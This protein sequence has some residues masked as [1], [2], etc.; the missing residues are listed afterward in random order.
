MKRNNRYKSTYN[1]ALKLIADLPLASGLPTETVLSKQLLASRT[2]I[3]A[4]LSQLASER[5]IEWRGRTKLV[6]RRPI[7]D[8]YYVFAETQS[9][10]QLIET[11]F[12]QW[13][14]S[15]DIGEGAT[16]KETELAEEFGV[17]ISALREFLIRFSRF[18]LI[19]KQA[20][21][22]WVLRGFTKA[23]ALEL[24]DV[25]EMF[26]L[27]S[28][29]K[30]LELPESDV[31]WKE[32]SSLENRHLALTTDVNMDN[33]TFSQLDEHFHRL[34][35][36]AANNRFV[37]DFHDLISMIFHY[38]YRWNKHDERERNAVAITQHLAIIDAL[39]KREVGKART[40]CCTHLASARETLLNS[41]SWQ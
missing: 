27:R 2:T 32:L 26:E 41:I 33:L 25:R 1:Q 8:D 20:N 22:G 19:E 38:H 23:F 9:T 31:R 24:S 7:A 35:N 40:A 11:A 21:R 14:L 29:E 17:S 12:M 36:S 30:F 4:V 13:I 28:I 18:G 39:K 37:T 10:N 16:F 3:R 6:L 15:G 5:I 34:I